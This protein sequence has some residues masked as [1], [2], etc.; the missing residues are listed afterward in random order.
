MAW[1]RSYD[2]LVAG[3]VLVL[4]C[5]TLSCSGD[6]AGRETSDGAASAAVVPAETA[7]AGRA[8]MQSDM[9]G[10]AQRLALGDGMAF[11]GDISGDPFVHVIRVSDGIHLT[12]LGRR[13]EGPGELTS[14]QGL[15]VDPQ[16]AATVI[17]FDPNQ[18]RL[19]WFALGDSVLRN[20]PLTRDLTPQAPTIN[21]ITPLARGFVALASD[22][23]LYWRVMDSSGTIG[24]LTPATLL[25]GD[26]IP[27]DARLTASR[28]IRICSRPDGQ[29]FAAAY[30][31]AGRV[32]IRDGDGTLVAAADVP[33]PTDGEWKV[34]EKTNRLTWTRTQSHYSDCTGTSDRIYALF[35]G[36][37]DRS[38][39]N[40]RPPGANEGSA[41]HVFDWSGRLLQIFRLNHEVAAIAV[42]SDARF[43]YGVSGQSSTLYEFPLE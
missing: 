4:A 17:T 29:F 2:S 40:G 6:T 7:I 38:G 23:I 42:G 22:S 27:R 21:T 24:A 36:K 10:K 1:I 13:G 25:G 32:E 43:L 33:T 26:S 9:F 3:G 14:L 19:T 41:V 30:Y 35:A 15:F 28:T 31:G 16:D 5:G 34:S 8:V 12:S 37:D 39:P 11:V 20:T 18:R